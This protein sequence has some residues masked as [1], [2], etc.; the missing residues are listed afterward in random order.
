MDYLTLFWV[1]VF[2]VFTLFTGLWASRKGKDKKQGQTELIHL[3]L[4]GRQIPLWVGALTMTATWVGGGYINGTAEVVYTQGLIWAQAPWGYA[5]SLIVGGLFF[6]KVMRENEYTTLLD[7]FQQKY[8][9]KVGS[10]LFIPALIGE[11]FWSA[12]ILTALGYTFSILL[13]LNFETAIIVS[14]STAIAYTFMGGL[15]SVAYTDVIQLIFILLDSDL[16]FLMLSILQGALKRFGLTIK[17]TLLTT[18]GLSLILILF[19]ERVLRETYGT[20]K[21]GTGLI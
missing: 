6:A 13:E 1:F 18:P 20:N 15:W 7:P 8:G 14:A 4:A 17:I 5:L 19:L 3:F 10:L 11:I 21:F 9:N 12:A 2:Y 16:L